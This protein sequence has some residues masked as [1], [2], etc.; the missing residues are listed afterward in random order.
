MNLIEIRHPAGALGPEDQ[1]AMAAEITMGLT[2]DMGDDIVPES[3]LRRARAMTHVA[4]AELAGWQTGDGT[5]GA[6]GDVPPLWITV[7]VPEAWRDEIARHEMGWL[8]RAVHR[9]DND[10]GWQRPDGWLWINLVGVADGSIGLDGKAMTADGV[11][12]EMSR[13]FRSD[14]DAGKVEVPDGML[15][16]P[17]CGMLVKDRAQAI[18]LEH[19][20]TRYGFC[21]HSCRDAFVRRHAS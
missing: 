9:V 2:G 11:V 13:E 19:D 5:W 8:R 17:M 16:D 7:T 18:A 10:H 14:L 15:L 6:P 3:T 21:A 12:A 20:G 4:F 1:T